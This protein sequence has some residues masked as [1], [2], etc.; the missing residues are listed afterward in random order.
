MSVFAQP[1]TP[2]VQVGAPSVAGAAASPQGGSNGGTA[3]DRYGVEGETFRILTEAVIFEKAEA[4]AGTRR[5]IGGLIHSIRRDREDEVIYR[6][7]TEGARGLLFKDFARRGMFN[8]DHGAFPHEVF[9][10]ADHTSIRAY[11]KG[12]MMPDGRLAP[13]DGVWAEGILLDGYP[14]AERLWKAAQEGQVFRFSIEGDILKRAGA[15]GR[16]VPEAMVKHVAVTRDPMNYDTAMMVMSKSA[17]SLRK[18]LDTGAAA[19]LIPESL[20]YCKSCSAPMTKSCSSRTC[21]LRAGD[22][23][24]QILAESASGK[25]KASDKK[26]D[27]GKPPWMRKAT[28]TRAEAVVTVLALHPTLS[29]ADAGQLV[30]LAIARSTR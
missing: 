10:K 9:A 20:D 11:D 16:D 26:D 6:D 27:A 17:E 2:A 12:Q 13:N 5:R 3:A 8:D 14:P 19:A 22:A 15:N 21:G 4:P 28:L 30:D 23:A 1:V 29:C 24:S 7:P 25:D 18:A